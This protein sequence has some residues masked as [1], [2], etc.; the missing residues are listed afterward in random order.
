MTTALENVSA[1]STAQA[2]QAASQRDQQ[3]LAEDLDTFLTLLTTQ[4][5]NQDP[6]EP[7][8]TNQ[9]TQQLVQFSGVEQ[10]IQTN[11]YLEDLIT[12]TEA[13]AVNAAVSYIG[14]TVRANGT[15]APLQNGTATWDLSADIGAPASTI[16]VIN[17]A[18][19]VV[20]SSP[21]SVERGEST[22]VWDG[23][24]NGGA[25][26]PDGTYSIRVEGATS[27]GTNVPVTTSIRGEVTGV[28]LTNNEP[29]LLINDIRVN[30]SSVLSLQQSES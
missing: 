14:N 19:Q 8:D 6:L 4:L 24:S 7:L 11:S 12:S 17:D 15:V 2:E 16:S 30:L 9:F 20:Y 3:L 27:D 25:Q 23:R 1:A 21:H 22:F 28:D 18:G 5:Q 26:Q 10:Q 29:V 13:Q